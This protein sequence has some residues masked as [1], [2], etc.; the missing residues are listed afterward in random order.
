[1]AVCLRRRRMWPFPGDRP[2]GAERRPGR[3]PLSVDDCRGAAAGRRLRRRGDSIVCLLRERGAPHRRNTGCRG[4]GLRTIRRAGH[5]A[6]GRPRRLEPSKGGCARCGGRCHREWR[7]VEL[8]AGA[9]RRIRKSGTV[10][11][12]A[13]LF[14][15]VIGVR[16]PRDVVDRGF[17]RRR[18]QLSLRSRLAAAR[19]VRC[20]SRRL[21]GTARV[22]L[23]PCS[24]R[25]A[26]DR[27]RTRR[28]S[29]R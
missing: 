2:D 7:V 14:S 18:A 3:P 21:M 4:R 24:Y 10:V 25:Q 26:F 17:V 9:D 23:G 5:R 22:V 19:H 27:R 12:S 28:G 20:V 6:G 29:S 1:M 13:T 16:A 8:L 15:F 11:R